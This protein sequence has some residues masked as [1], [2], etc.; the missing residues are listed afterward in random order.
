MPSRADLDPTEIPHLLPNLILNDVERDPLRFRI[1]L[2][3]TAI[4][5]ARGWDATGRYLDEANVIMLQN[6][7]VEA[8]TRLTEDCQPWYSEGSFAF[9]D[10]RP[11]RLYRLALPMIR[12]GPAVDLIMVGFYHELTARPDWGR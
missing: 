7:V 8:Y 5:D 10:G 3:G 2:E 9:G 4:R 12:S 1:R 6:D 11:G